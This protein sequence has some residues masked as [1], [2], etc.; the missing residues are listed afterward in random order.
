MP[1]RTPAAEPGVTRWFL[2]LATAAALLALPPAN[3]LLRDPDWR[4]SPRFDGQAYRLSLEDVVLQSTD[5]TGAAAILATLENWRGHDVDEAQFAAELTSEGFGG[6]LAEIADAAA[7]RGFDGRWIEVARADFPRLNVPF[8]AH[9][10]DDGGRLA[11]VRRV[12]LGH[13]YVA[14]PTR[15]QVLY[16][17]DRFLATWTGNA[18]AFPDPPPQPATW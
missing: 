11:I 5:P 7:A 10:S 6:G 2:V 18:F 3:A 4:A 17:I 13:V 9:L 15:G 14:D 1:T 8:V 16:P 12:A